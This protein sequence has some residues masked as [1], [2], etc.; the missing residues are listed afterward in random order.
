[1]TA[2]VETEIALIRQRLDQLVD[3]LERQHERYDTLV[4]RVD[5]HSKKFIAADAAAGALSAPDSSRTP[6][7]PRAA[8]LLIGAGAAGGGVTLGA[9]LKELLALFL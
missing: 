1:M 7:T 3:Q 8:Q 5:E 4:G 9:L 2:S 6:I